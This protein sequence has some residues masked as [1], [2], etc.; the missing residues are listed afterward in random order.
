MPPGRFLEVGNKELENLPNSPIHHIQA[1]KQ[2]HFALP[3]LS[4]RRVASRELAA[5]K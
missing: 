2:M 1:P 3:N 5:C 4:G